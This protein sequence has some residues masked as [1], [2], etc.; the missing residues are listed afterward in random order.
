MKVP[1]KEVLKQIVDH[2]EFKVNQSQVKDVLKAIKSVTL[3]NARNGFG[4]KLNPLGNFELKITKPKMTC[5]NLKLK[6]GSK[7]VVSPSNPMIS[8]HYMAR[9]YIC[10]KIKEEIAKLP[11]TK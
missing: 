1:K 3:F 7:I 5:H 8:L 6:N 4:T 2:C 9:F 11:L 10:D